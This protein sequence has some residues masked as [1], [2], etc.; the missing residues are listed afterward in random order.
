MQLEKQLNLYITFEVYKT[1]LPF[2]MCLTLC[3]ME[4][5]GTCESCFAIPGEEGGQVCLIREM[6][7]IAFCQLSN[8]PTEETNQHLDTYF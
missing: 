5:S 2:F 1:F 4:T 3:E 6:E 8:C 7:S